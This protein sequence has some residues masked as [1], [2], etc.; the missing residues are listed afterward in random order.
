[1]SAPPTPAPKAASVQRSMF[2]HGSRWVII[3]SDV[4]ACTTAAP[5]PGS[6]TTSATRAHS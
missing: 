6:P 3:G 2:T 1:M 5:P 4:S